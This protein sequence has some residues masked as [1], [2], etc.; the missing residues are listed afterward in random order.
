MGMLTFP[1][2][3]KLSVGIEDRVANVYTAEDEA[4]HKSWAAEPIIDGGDIEI[5]ANFDQA[6]SMLR[7]RLKDV[8]ADDPRGKWQATPYQVA[9]A[10]SK[11]ATAVAMVQAWLESQA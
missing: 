5:S 8:D 11:D 4:E 2:G 3:S 6:S 9:D 10:G 7:W 1:D